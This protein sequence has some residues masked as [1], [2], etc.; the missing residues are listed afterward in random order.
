M[1]RRFTLNIINLLTP[2]RAIKDVRK[3]KLEKFDQ[4]IEELKFGDDENMG[5]LYKHSVDLLT[6]RSSFIIGEFTPSA[7]RLYIVCSNR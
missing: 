6:L 2:F 5:R 4:I 1:D 3:I 7:S